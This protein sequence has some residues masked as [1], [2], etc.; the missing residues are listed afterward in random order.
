MDNVKIFFLCLVYIFL[1][2]YLMGNIIGPVS[3]TI[4]SAVI[5]AG[6]ML[7]FSNS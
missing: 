5:V 3:T 1:S 6:A 7:L 2:R 4:L